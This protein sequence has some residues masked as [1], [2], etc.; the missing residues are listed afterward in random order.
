MKLNTWLKKQDYSQTETE[1]MKRTTLVTTY[2]S[3]A[4]KQSLEY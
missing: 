4:G 3:N 1:N 2:N